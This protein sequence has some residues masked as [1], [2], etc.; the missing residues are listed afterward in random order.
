[1][2]RTHSQS[3]NQPIRRRP[4]VPDPPRHAP[5]P[6]PSDSPEPGNPSHPPGPP[7]LWQTRQPDSTAASTRD[8][9]PTTGDPPR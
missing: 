4:Y 2:T 1:M 7:K 5:D 6:G 8:S 3:G 9:R